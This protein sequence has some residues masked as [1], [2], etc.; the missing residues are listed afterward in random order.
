MACIAAPNAPN[1]PYG[2]HTRT[3]SS[4]RALR[5]QIASSHS[6][7]S[8]VTGTAH[9]HGKSRRCAGVN[10][11]RPIGSMCPFV[12]RH[13]LLHRGAKKE[14]KPL[15]H[16]AQKPLLSRATHSV[17]ACSAAAHQRFRSVTTPSACSISV[18]CDVKRSAAN[19][20]RCHD[21]S[22]R[23]ETT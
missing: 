3:G 13:R 12:R 5:A 19:E 7:A 22:G 6:R 1:E 21:D 23:L 9:R 16:A 2:S 17:S 4:N 11:P 18:S 8:R 14:R 15:I 10:R 20:M